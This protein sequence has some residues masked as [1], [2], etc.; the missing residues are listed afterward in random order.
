[1]ILQLESLKD[2]KEEVE[3]KI[4]VNDI[5]NV[6]KV[7]FERE[8]EKNDFI[9]LIKLFKKFDRRNQSAINEDEF[10]EIILQSLEKLPNSKRF[11]QCYMRINFQNSTFIRCIDQPVESKYENKVG[12]LRMGIDVRYCLQC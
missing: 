3:R 9:K 5:L 12:S 11:S 1:V 10:K 4:I 2:R 7:K 6:F 8:K